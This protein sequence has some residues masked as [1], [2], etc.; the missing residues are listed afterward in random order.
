MNILDY[1]KL[2]ND[3]K[4]LLINKIKYLYITLNKSKNVI[5][6][7]LN[8]NSKLLNKILKENNILKSKEMINKSKSDG[9]IKAYLEKPE[10]KNKIKQTKLERY[11]N[12]NY[13]N[14]EKFKETLNNNPQIVEHMIDNIKQTF[15]KKY[16]TEIPMQLESVKNK[17]KQTCLKK[18]G[19]ENPYQSKVIKEKIKQ[20][21]IENYG[22]DNISKSAIWKNKFKEKTLKSNFKINRLNKINQT[23]R[24]KYD[25]EWPCQL[26]QCINK[27]NSISKINQK[28]ASLLEENNISFEQEFVLGN[29][30][31]D[32]KIEN[33][34]IE[35]DPS[36]T[37][38][39]TIG[40]GFNGHYENPLSKNYHLEKSKLAIKNGFFCIHVFDW[41][42]WNKVINLLLSKKIV[43]AK[44]CELKEVSKK[45]CDKFL[46]FYHLQN[47]CNGQ[48]VK[49]GL[50]YN[51]ELVQ[52][53]TFGKPR[54]NKNYEWELL[55]LC[56]N[57]DYK[58]VGGSE[59]L[60]K[61]FIRHYNPQSII[62]YCD[63]SKF[64]GEVYKR[65][66][67]ILLSK[68]S[69]SCNWSKGKEKITN[70]L[71]MQ[72]G[73]DQ[74]FNANYGKGTPNRNL[75]IQNGWVEV[76]DCGQS[77]YIWN[78]KE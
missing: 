30:K 46:N 70:N 28:F 58:I 24:E 57:K 44:N 51:N 50:Y 64:S 29:R 25:I 21:L 65:L 78:N 33:M 16:G 18:Y 76:Y 59:K 61:N 27:S 47:T 42:N 54:Y 26:P 43:Y 60:F 74:L 9:K 40:C 20:N 63:N 38:N 67:M 52:I 12:E 17:F 36:Y 73:Y 68:G 66:E 8:I 5:V 13:N 37:H 72:R 11:G 77:S 34:L 6:D 71:L 53:M 48:K 41:D 75:M 69:P 2:N 10:I 1:K 22:V 31:F 55:R 14:R 7:D 49:Y 19:V 56:S 45:E 15:L 3:E 32:F 35:I 23:C 4:L 39:S 62:S